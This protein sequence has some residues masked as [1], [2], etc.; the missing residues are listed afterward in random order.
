MNTLVPHAMPWLALVLIVAAA[1]AALGA[2]SA[3]SLV[4]MCIR[5]AAAGALG[6]ATLLALGYGTG[7]LSLALFGAGL[8]PVLLMAGVLVST[9]AS[10][11]AKTPWFS[12]IAAAG[13]VGAI[14]WAATELNAL[15]ALPRSDGSSSAL[16]VALIVFVTAA[17]CAALL[18]YGERGI[19]EPKQGRFE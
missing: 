4:A 5:L 11:R 17:A 12:A 3:R 15:P 16:W 7:A 19:L 18:G 14:G 9:Q 8:A 2:L 13:V 10:K 6:A 1:V